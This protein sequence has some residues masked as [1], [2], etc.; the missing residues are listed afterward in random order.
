MYQIRSLQLGGL[1]SLVRRWVLPQL[2][3]TSSFLMAILMMSCRSNFLAMPVY[4][5]KFSDFAIHS[6]FTPS[7][8]FLSH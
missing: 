3:L 6:D 2:H 4:Y 5:L 8:P 7:V 1:L